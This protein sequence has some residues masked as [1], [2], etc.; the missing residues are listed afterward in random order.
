VGGTRRAV[1][2]TG[3]FRVALFERSFALGANEA[4]AMPP[5]AFCLQPLTL[6]GLLA[7]ETVSTGGGDS[8]L[9]PAYASRGT[10]GIQGLC[11]LERAGSAQQGFA[12]GLLLHDSKATRTRLDHRSAVL[13]LETI[14]ME[15]FAPRG[16][17][18]TSDIFLAHPAHPARLLG[19]E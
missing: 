1:V 11:A 16:Q 18:A 6:D 2:L 19:L 4:R 7:F 10:T 15:E 8:G 14:G 13:A 12:T 5:M 17:E 3:R 9:E